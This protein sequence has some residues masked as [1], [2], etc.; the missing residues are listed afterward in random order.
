[1][2]AEQQAVYVGL[3]EDDSASN[4]GW[5]R[6][7]IPGL[8]SHAAG[9]AI[10]VDVSAT[11]SDEH[12]IGKKLMRRQNMEIERSSHAIFDS[13]QE[14]ERIARYLVVEHGGIL[15]VGRQLH[16]I[17]ASLIDTAVASDRFQ[18]RVSLDTVED[19][20]TMHDYPLSRREEQ[21]ICAYYGTTP[22]W[23]E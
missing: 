5:A 22:Y 9:G 12:D 1:M 19:G 4:E 21:T 10:V 14:R 3:L 13:R 11:K 6:I 23:D 20:P 15:G 17:P 8:D 18:V 16:A 7:E 2:F